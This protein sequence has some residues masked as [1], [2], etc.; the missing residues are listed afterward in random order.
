VFSLEVMKT[1]AG[2]T[3]L[4]SE[5]SAYSMIEASLRHLRRRLDRVSFTSAK[6]PP[7][8]ALTFIESSGVHIVIHPGLGSSSAMVPVN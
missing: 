6:L 7:V 4:R 8:S 5:V 3:I 2:A 1:E